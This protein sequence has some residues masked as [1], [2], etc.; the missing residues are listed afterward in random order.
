MDPSV[1][2]TGVLY[3]TLHNSCH[4]STINTLLPFVGKGIQ[5]LR[6]PDQIGVTLLYIMVQMQHSGREPL[7]NTHNYVRARDGP[8]NEFLHSANLSTLH[9]TQGLLN[10]WLKLTVVHTKS[11]PS[12]LSAQQNG[13]CFLTHL[14]VCWLWF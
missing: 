11:V 2:I 10:F 3:V 8:D 12:H 1:F 14:L 6:V 9:T 5:I 4:Q 7:I 13:S